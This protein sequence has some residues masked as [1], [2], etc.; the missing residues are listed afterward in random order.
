M[1]VAHIPATGQSVAV[2]SVREVHRAGAQR[3]KYVALVRDTT[4]NANLS[5]LSGPNGRLAHRPYRSRVR[6]L[7][8]VAHCDNSV[9]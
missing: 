3:T 2:D 8:E 5:P 4:M 1:R 7:G 6:R 9:C